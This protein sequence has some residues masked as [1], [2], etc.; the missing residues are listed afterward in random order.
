VN[1]QLGASGRR[2]RAGGHYLRA[3]QTVAW[4]EIARAIR[5]DETL[6]SAVLPIGEGL[7]VAT[8]RS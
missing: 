5:E 1:S 6:V 4:R 8:G 3:A 2:P 7:L